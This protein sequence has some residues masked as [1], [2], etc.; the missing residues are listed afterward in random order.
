MITG[1]TRLCAILADPIAHVRTPETFNALMA[2]GGQDAVLVPMHVTAETLAV[3]VTALRDIANLAGFVVTVPHKAAMVALC[4]TL[5]D[6]ART[7]GAVN[8]VQRTADGK[9]RGHILDGEGFV[10]GLRQSGIEPAGRSA[11]VA[12][13]GG[14]ASAIAFA[15]AA[16]GVSRIGIWNRTRAKAEELSVRLGRMENAPEIRVENADPTGYDIVVNATSLGLRESDPMPF[17]ADRLTADQIVAEIIMKPEWTPLL[18]EA[19]GRGCRVALGA[20]MLDCQLR[21]MADFMGV[22][23]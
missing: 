19:K 14:A 3:S 16:A 17:A 18:L 10:S 9:L 22:P 8:I 4:D 21:L 13:A 23:A 5:T 6:A 7:V 11:Y 20:P 1:R 15:L 2:A 12:G